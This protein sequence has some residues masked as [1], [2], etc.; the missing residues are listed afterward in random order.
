MLTKDQLHEAL[1]SH[2]QQPERDWDLRFA[3]QKS[4]SEPLS[5]Y[6]ANELR[7]Y[8]RDLFWDGTKGVKTQPIAEVINELVEEYEDQDLP[9]ETF[10]EWKEDWLN[11]EREYVPSDD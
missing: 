7:E 1:T 5:Q 6:S 4:H 8:L 2:A 11:A 9:V 10:D 3:L